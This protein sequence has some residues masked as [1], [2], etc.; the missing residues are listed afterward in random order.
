M[1]K[2][3]DSVFGY[4]VIFDWLNKASMDLW[5]FI[6]VLYRQSF[7][8]FWMTIP[9]ASFIAVDSICPP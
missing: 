8:S 1:E 9:E 3:K 5:M 7:S 4:E 6:R 2:I